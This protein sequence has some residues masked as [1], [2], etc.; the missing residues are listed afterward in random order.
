MH[1]NMVGRLCQRPM[2]AQPQRTIGLHKPGRHE[3][4]VRHEQQQPEFAH[5]ECTFH[6]HMQNTLVPSW[7]PPLCR[8]DSMRDKS[9]TNRHMNIIVSGPRLPIHE[10]AKHGK[11]EPRKRPVSACL[12]VSN[13][14]T[15]SFQS[16]GSFVTRTTRQANSRSGATCDSSGPLDKRSCWPVP[17][18]NDA[19]W[20]KAKP[21]GS[22]TRSKQQPAHSKNGGGSGERRLASAHA[23][24]GEGQICRSSRLETSVHL[25][26]AGEPPA[27][28]QGVRS[29]VNSG[30]FLGT[31]V[32]LV[33]GRVQNAERAKQRPA[34]AKAVS[35]RRIY[36]APV[37]VPWQPYIEAGKLSLATLH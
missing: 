10:H 29:L 17:V 26:N 28:H 5:P 31:P 13:E 35:N 33:K 8:H 3:D 16:A 34:S 21:L 11:L 20:H 12:P 1:E 23:S 9:S 7:Q 24:Q 37:S 4:R 15:V 27:P 6:L 25:R 36:V 14:M 32:P 30:S 22:K 18:G 2:S 19:P